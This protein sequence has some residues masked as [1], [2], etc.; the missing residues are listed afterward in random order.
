MANGAGRVNCGRDAGTDTPH[1]GQRSYHWSSRAFWPQGAEASGLGM[2]YLR[3]SILWEKYE[4][5]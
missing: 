3:G 2:F 5:R 4:E 1:T